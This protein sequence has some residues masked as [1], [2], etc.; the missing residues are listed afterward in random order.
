[1]NLGSTHTSEGQTLDV[2]KN[3][4][5]LFNSKE[6]HELKLYYGNKSFFDI[7]GIMRNENV[8]SD[9]LAWILDTEAN[10]GLNEYSIRK[11]LEM[12]VMSL[13]DC[14]YA[15]KYNDLFPEYLIDYIITGNYHVSDVKIEREK[16]ID[17]NKRIDLFIDL[18]IKIKSNSDENINVKIILENKVYS[19]EHSDQ[20]NQYYDWAERN[21]KE[22]SELVYIYLTPTSNRE[23]LELEDQHSQC[24][25]YIQINYQYL[26]DYVL[27]PCRMQQISDEAKSLIDNYLRCLSYP[28][29]DEESIKNGGLVMAVSEREKRLLLDFW[30]TNK[31]LLL[32]MLNVLKDDDSIDEQE[33]Q[34]MDSMISTISNKSNK[35]F[36]K[37]KFKGN[38]YGKNRL[39]LAVVKEYLSSSNVTYDELKDIFPDNIQGTLGVFQ[40][41]EYAE[42]KDRRR[43]F[44]KLD[45]ILVTKDGIRI[46]VCTQWGMP[47]IDGFIDAAS[48]LGY[49]IEPTNL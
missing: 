29:L 22:N 13:F 49:E 2:R 6:Y 48:R 20:T 36:T 23:L 19:K 47:K 24:K 14:K 26:V 16:V 11:F 30:E 32:A 41:V 5:Q 44:L 7:L 38:V 15:N 39:V 33:R 21:F 40:K 3:I 25:K 28:S 8:H 10:H 43:Y 42:N 27:E 18:T 12:V 17:N 37:Y 9:F 35:D 4:I 31:P 46:A 34:N 1:M 45:E